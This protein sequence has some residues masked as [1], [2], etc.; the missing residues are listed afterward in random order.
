MEDKMV[1][2]SIDLE[3]NPEKE[4]SKVLLFHLTSSFT[5][6]AKNGTSKIQKVFSSLLKAEFWQ[7][8]ACFLRV[9]TET[10]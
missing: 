4:R 6:G 3:T 7:R 5:T 1:I 9:Q 8:Q 2:E 10:F